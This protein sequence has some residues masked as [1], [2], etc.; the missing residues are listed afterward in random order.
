MKR[1]LLSVT[2]ACSLLLAIAQPNLTLTTYATGFDTPADIANA[3]DGRLFVVEQPGVIQVV[4]PGGSVNA[5]PFLD[6]QSIVNDS[7]WE[8]GL[9]GLAFH[10]DYAT[11]G[12]FYVHYTDAG[13]DGQISRFTV[14]GGD[15]DI[16]DAGS[17]F[18][19]INIAQPFSNHNGGCIRFGPDDY[20]YIGMGDGGSAGDPGGRAQDSTELLGKMLRIDVD[21]GSPYAVPADNPFVGNA[22]WLDEI[23]AYG[24]RNP[25]KF[26]FDKANGDLFIG[27]VGQ[28]IWEEV[29]YA[30]ATSTGGENYG[31]RCYEASA[32]YNTTGCDL[33]ATYSWPI[34]EY[35]QSGAPP[36]GCTVI[37]GHVYRG[38]Q[39]PGMQ[40]YYFFAE[41]CGDWIY[42]LYWT[43]TVWQ[44][45]DHG[46]FAGGSWTTFGEG[47]DGEL[48]IAD[49]SSGFVYH[50]EDLNTGIIEYENAV[51][52][53]YPNPSKEQTTISFLNENGESH[54]LDIFDLTGKI[55]YSQS[56]ITSSQIVVETNQFDAGFY[57]FQLKFEG[58]SVGTG[59]LIVE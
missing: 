53:V 40:G 5:T 54:T 9:L 34:Y 28:D 31:W 22:N 3:G 55:I 52:N 6:I 21:G 44:D 23:W 46:T 58:T 38:T 18:P 16:A 56:G 25:W 48:Y 2:S 26:S 13:G 50:L 12:Y 15:P 32:T 47:N 14:S 49:Q 36:N 4:Q 43:G 39:H 1:I 30:P 29:S 35:N 33:G 45:Y 37:G 27:D 20:L 41:F 57:S 42:S 59:K 19:I 7:G 24:L 11:N 17:E 10:P 51:N 8:R